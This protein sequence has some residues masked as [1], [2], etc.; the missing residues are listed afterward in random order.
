MGTIRHMILCSYGLFL[1]GSIRLF[2][3]FSE[4][5]CTDLG[6]YNIKEFLHD[7]PQISSH[8]SSAH[9]V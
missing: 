3:N 7:F 6:D 2:R 1:L 9:N 5:S 4:R 8:T